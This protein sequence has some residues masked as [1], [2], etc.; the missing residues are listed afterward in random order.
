[1]FCQWGEWALVRVMKILKCLSSFQKGISL[2]LRPNVCW[3]L[4]QEGWVLPKSERSCGYIPR[5]KPIFWASGLW[6]IDSHFLDIAIRKCMLYVWR[7]V[8]EK[9]RGEEVM[10]KEIR[11]ISYENV[12][13]EIWDWWNMRK[14]NP[15]PNLLS[16]PRRIQK[17]SIH[18][19][20]KTANK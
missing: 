14:G 20:V 17:W 2:I 15:R 18:L 4:K 8:L 12:E 16:K 19:H 1:M 13:K 9:K 6:K 5:Y 3:D 10:Y 7:G 11:V